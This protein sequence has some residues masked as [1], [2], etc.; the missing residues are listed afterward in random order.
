MF[1]WI[2]TLFAKST[3]QLTAQKSSTNNCHRL[4]RLKSFVKTEKVVYLLHTQTNE[5]THQYYMPT[6]LVREISLTFYL[7]WFHKIM[8][9]KMQLTVVDEAWLKTTHNNK[10]NTVIIT[11]FFSAA[12]QIRN[13]GFSSWPLPMF[14]FSPLL[15]Y[16]LWLRVLD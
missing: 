1:Q 12:P 14:S 7:V 15:L 10:I 8:A 11:A 6:F 3:S 13:P 16:L 2:I 9:M 5:Q 4:G